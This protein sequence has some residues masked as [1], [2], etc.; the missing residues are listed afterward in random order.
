VG[1]EIEEGHG[2]WSYLKCA[3]EVAKFKEHCTKSKKSSKSLYKLEQNTKKWI[4][5]TSVKEKI[6]K[7][8]NKIGTIK[9]CEELRRR[10]WSFNMHIFDIH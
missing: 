9:N 6:S 2:H 10:H 5:S 1:I 3:K 7:K 4:N 8:R